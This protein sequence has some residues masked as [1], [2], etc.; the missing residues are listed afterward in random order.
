MVTCTWDV[1]AIAIFASAASSELHYRVL[2]GETGTLIGR[3]FT[4]RVRPD[5]IVDD[6]VVVGHPYTYRLQVLRA[7]GRVVA[8]SGGTEVICCAN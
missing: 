2:R 3:V 8:Q 4:P 6:L 5:A 7:D 1:V